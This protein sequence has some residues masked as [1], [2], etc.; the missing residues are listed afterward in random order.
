MKVLKI[1]FP[2]FLLFTFFACDSDYEAEDEENE[3][4]YQEEF[5]GVYTGSIVINQEV[6]DVI[7]QIGAGDDEYTLQFSFDG[8]TFDAEIFSENMFFLDGSLFEYKQ[9]N[10]EVI[11][12]AGKLNL[13]NYTIEA[14]V[15]LSNIADSEEEIRMRFTI[16]R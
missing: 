1:F 4:N 16:D 10:Y 5:I 13:E 8:Y 14:K 7:V 15:I 3:T 6:E 12:G 2:V 11:R 9:Q